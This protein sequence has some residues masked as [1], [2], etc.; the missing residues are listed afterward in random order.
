MCSSALTSAG[1][2]VHSGFI[3][4]SVTT[5][6]SPSLRSTSSS[7]GI[8]VFPDDGRDIDTLLKRAD[9]AMYHAKEAGRNAY[10]FF[11]EQMNLDAVE[12]QQV[13]VGLLHAME[14]GEFRLH[15]Q[16]Q[17]DINSGKVIGAEALIRWQHPEE[18]LL[19]PAWFMPAVDTSELAVFV[20]Q[21]V[22]HQCL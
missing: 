17:I 8:A 19:S 11:T 12:H 21:W 3:E 18:G 13:R 2:R 1:G 10:S 20:G 7:I 14:R 6:R 5:S 22:I 4:F 16:P 9:T 15:Y